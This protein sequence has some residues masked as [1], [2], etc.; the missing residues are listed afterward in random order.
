MWRLNNQTRTSFYRCIL[1]KVMLRPWQRKGQII[2][3]CREGCIKSLPGFALQEGQ[4][5][6]AA[7]TLST[8]MK[9]DQGHHMWCPRGRK[10]PVKLGCYIFVF[11]D[12]V[13]WNL[14]VRGNTESTD[15]TEFTLYPVPTRLMSWKTSAQILIY[16]PVQTLSFLLKLVCVFTL[17]RYL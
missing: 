9:T 8:C 2:R 15:N 13:G 1:A 10:T 7:E 3:Q 17:V 4:S 5:A 6:R 12:I 16:P 14:I 11:G